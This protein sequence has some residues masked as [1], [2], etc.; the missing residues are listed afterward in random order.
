MGL[1][2]PTTKWS[3]FSTQARTAQR[4]Q[5]SSRCGRTLCP[6]RLP[7]ASSTDMEASA[8]A[9]VSAVGVMD[10]LRFHK[11]TVGYAWVSNY[12]CSDKKEEFPNL[13]GISPLHNIKAVEGVQHPATLIM[14]GDH[15]DMVV[16]SHSL[17]YCATL[18]NILGVNQGQTQPLMMRVD[19]KSGHGAG[20]PT[21]KSIEEYTDIFCFLVKSLG[22]QYKK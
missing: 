14:T 22:L 7:P 5:C 13:L 11:Y 15:D 4:F 21:S 18:Q 3:K 20:K 19:T 1:R 16:P 9:A 6:T 10:M 17:K 2:T 8:S 12:G